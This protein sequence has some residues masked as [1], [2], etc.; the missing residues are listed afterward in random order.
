[1]AST[2]SEVQLAGHLKLSQGQVFADVH[3][4]S[5]RGRVDGLPPLTGFTSVDRMRA[6]WGETLGQVFDSCGHGRHDEMQVCVSQGTHSQTN[7][8]ALNT[9]T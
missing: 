3:R 6:E 1:M 5:Q 2:V 7:N 4:W 9:T 8:A